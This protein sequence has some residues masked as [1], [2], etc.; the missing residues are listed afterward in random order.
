M[1][2]NKIPARKNIILL[3]LKVSLMA[4]SLKF[5]TELFR[6]FLLFPFFLLFVELCCIFKL[7]LDVAL[8]YK[9]EFKR[10]SFANFVRIFIV[11]FHHLAPAQ[12]TLHIWIAST[13]QSQYT[14]QRQHCFSSFE[15]CLFRIFLR[16]PT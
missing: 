8:N 7:G 13:K 4:R 1:C 3:Q 11:S 10:Q 16:L 12:N 9:R 5:M 6:F 2:F 14:E 15:C